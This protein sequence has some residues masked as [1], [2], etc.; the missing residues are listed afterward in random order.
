MT[1]DRN[2]RESGI[3]KLEREM[4]WGYKCGRMDPSM[5]DHGRRIRHVER[6]G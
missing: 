4:E 2:M 6:E 1:M 5:R 3:L